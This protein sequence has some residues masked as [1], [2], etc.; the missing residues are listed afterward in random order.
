MKRIAICILV[1][2]ACLLFVFWAKDTFGE[3]SAEYNLGMDSLRLSDSCSIVSL[4]DSLSNSILD[5]IYKVMESFNRW[6]HQDSLRAMI[7]S[8]QG[9]LRILNH[10]PKYTEERKVIINYYDDGT[11][12]TIWIDLF[13]D[14]Y[15][16]K[17][18]W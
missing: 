9:E 15:M 8:L 2:L 5:I 13:Y 16:I 4:S 7:D 17:A 6:T 12:D 18:E 14:K 1:L 10:T 3:D 11:V